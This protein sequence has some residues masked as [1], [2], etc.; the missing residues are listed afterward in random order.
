MT[1]FTRQ[2]FEIEVLSD[3]GPIS[4]SLDNIN[5]EI[6]EGHCSGVIKE[7]IRE[8]QIPGEKMAKLLINQDSDPEFFGLDENGNTVTE[9]E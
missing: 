1:N 2:V 8:E 6:T 3:D 4:G 7:I 5:Y 9:D